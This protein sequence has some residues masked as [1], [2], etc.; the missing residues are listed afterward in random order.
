MV[1]EARKSMSA[2][3]K[4]DVVTV[5]HDSQQKVE[6]RGAEERKRD[7]ARFVNQF[8]PGRATLILWQVRAH[9]LTTSD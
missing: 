5:L 2:V 1:L 8:T 7:R 6:D 4:S 3:P 9:D